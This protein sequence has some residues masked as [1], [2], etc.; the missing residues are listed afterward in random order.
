[1]FDLVEL[2][3]ALLE[4]LYDYSKILY[5]VYAADIHIPIKNHKEMLIIQI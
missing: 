2:L 1:M 5:V 4:I 3:F